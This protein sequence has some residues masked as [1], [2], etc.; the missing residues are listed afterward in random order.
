MLDSAST[1]LFP[2]VPRG[3]RQGRR[4]VPGHRRGRRRRRLCRPRVPA[5]GLDPPAAAETGRARPGPH[6][7]GD[8]P[9]GI[10]PGPID[11]GPSGSGPTRRGLVEPG[12]VEPGLVECRL[13]EP[14][15]VERALTECLVVARS[16][17][18]VDGRRRPRRDGGHLEHEH[19]GNLGALRRVRPGLRQH[20]RH[21]ARAPLRAR[22]RRVRR[23]RRAGPPPG[24]RRRGRP[25]RRR[26]RRDRRPQPWCGCCA[27][28]GCS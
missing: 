13:V 2:A 5:G 14:G 1:W 17:Q 26:A 19:A 21:P 22:R 27:G 8:A 10:G 12:L 23:V 7:L 3:R 28:R 20:P 4:P 24:R 6:V 15:L 18:T 25:G 9:A 16:G 11:P